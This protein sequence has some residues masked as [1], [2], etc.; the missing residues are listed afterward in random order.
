M[1]TQVDSRIVTLIQAGITF[2][3]SDGEL[4][5]VLV[6][7]R[8]DGPTR[9]FGQF[10]PCAAVPNP[11]GWRT[12]EELTGI[13]SAQAVDGWNDAG[14]HNP[15]ADQAFKLMGEHIGCEFL[16][17]EI[18]GVGGFTAV[19]LV[20]LRID[21]PGVIPDEDDLPAFTNTDPVQTVTFQSV[22][23]SIDVQDERPPGFTIMTDGAPPHTI[24][25]PDV[26]HDP[27][28][29]A[30]WL[31]E[32]LTEVP[33]SSLA[34]SWIEV[35][36][37]KESATFT[38]TAV[39]LQTELAIAGEIPLKEDG[40]LDLDALRTRVI[41]ARFRAGREPKLFVGRHLKVMA[42]RSW[43][44][45][46]DTMGPHLF[47]YNV[48]RGASSGTPAVIR[49]VDGQAKLEVLD[50]EDKLRAV[51]T[52]CVQYVRAGKRNVIIHINPP[53]TTLTHMLTLADQAVN[54]I[55]TLVRIPTT[56]KDGTI[57]D[58][59][60]YDRRSRIWY[61]P[62][63][64]LEDVPQE[65]TDADVRLAVATVL[66]P[67]KEFPYVEDAGARTATIAC[68]MEQVV[69][70]M[71]D[72]PRPLYAFD[73]PAFR[74]Q[75]TGKCNCA[76]TLM[77]SNRGLMPI[78]DLCSA[79]L[80]PDESIGYAHYAPDETPVVPTHTGAFT[81]A[82]QFYNGGV[83]SCLRIRTRR[84]YTLGGTHVHPVRVATADGADF[85]QLRNVKPGDYVAVNVA[86]HPGADTDQIEPDC[87]YLL[88]ALTAD[89]DLNERDYKSA[90]TYTKS[91][92]ALRQR[93]YDL[94]YEYLDP[95]S[96]EPTSVNTTHTAPGWRFNG[97]DARER[98]RALD[99][100]QTT[101]AYKRIP[102]T[103]MRSSWRVW[104][105]FLRGLFDGDAHIDKQGFEWSTA[106]EELSHEVQVMLAALGVWC[107]RKPKSVQLEGW[108]APRT[109]W[110]VTFSG[111]DLDAYAEAVG[112]SDAATEKRDRL[113]ARVADKRVRNTN[114]DVIPPQ[115]IPLVYA[116]YKSAPPADKAEIHKWKLSRLQRANPS[117]TAVGELLLNR[118]SS[119]EAVQ[120]AELCVPHV[121]WDRVEEV[122]DIGERQ[123][124]DL[125]VPDDHSFVGNAIQQHN[126]LLPM[127]IGAIITGRRIGVTTWPE[128][129]KE[130]PKTITTKLLEADPFVIYDNL[131]GTVKHKDLSA[132]TTSQTWSN[133]LLHTNH[134]PKLAQT[135]TWCLTLNG[136]RFN[137]DI[138]RR[139]ILIRLDA[140]MKDPHKRRDFAIDNLIPWCIQR[141]A[142]II[143]ALLIMA[144]SW[145]V[146][147]CPSDSRLTW[148]SFEAWAQVIGGVLNYVGLHDL[149]TAIEQSHLRD[150]DTIEHETFIKRWREQLPDQL[151]TALMLAELAEKHQLYSNLLERARTPNWKGRQM[152]TV[153]RSLAG[154]SFDGWL[155]E[156]AEHR[157]NGQVQYRL[158]APRGT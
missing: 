139:V 85:C 83:K 64:L 5:G 80:Q 24:Q 14:T 38:R 68:L 54:P 28:P 103:V 127:A 102:R 134:A 140:R 55:D 101:A 133:R 111:A 153:L 35:T 158:N 58:Q 42:K 60:G 132:L 29:A 67:F 3:Q 104:V 39:K 61:A 11:P 22:Q 32:L 27:D 98:M 43:T 107:A 16:A 76:E 44:L 47:R 125:C 105:A 9:Q 146:A 77:I 136:A 110:R 150:V 106:S 115:A 96:V 116:V 81:P 31:V 66:A 23:T 1:T 75:G 143:R 118:P 120:L 145:V 137:R 72:G 49:M 88:G 119:P 78:E 87:A 33:A 154:H 73:A 114:L 135:S 92:S 12:I 62:E 144:R 129:P 124:Y 95:N 30:Y 141:R 123:V 17:N 93:V 10:L 51:V 45:L 21:D 15:V 109:Y 156:A 6:V 148:G 70:P 131:E 13:T 112:F 152:A 157:T 108:G 53:Q 4:W 18:D 86:R 121:R 36:V 41:R 84:G 20:P 82:E 63:M 57:H 142:S 147:G 34:H 122:E 19:E 138:A 94:A 149:P 71:I 48:Q 25:A 52:N 117:R 91:N 56:R 65:P 79:Q 97:D 7:Q 59:E 113:A 130:L 2:Q 46:R 126:T 74:G 69:R 89:G 128:D 155:V 151:V 100:S 37:G 40:T 8:K 90:P 99:L 26:D 50:D